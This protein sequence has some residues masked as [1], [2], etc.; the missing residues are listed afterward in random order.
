[1]SSDDPSLGDLIEQAIARCRGSISTMIPAV[2]TSFD[3][4]T[5][6]C[7]AKPAIMGREADPDTDVLLPLELQEVSNV[8]VQYQ[9]GGGCSFTFPLVPGDFVMLIMAEQSLDEWKTT[10]S[11]LSLPVDIRRF[12]PTDAIAVPGIRPPGMPLPPSAYAPGAVVLSAP[13]ILLG[14]SAA[15]SPLVL[16]TLLVAYLGQLLTWLNLH[17]HTGPGGLTGPP[18]PITGPAP[19]PGNLGAAKV[20]GE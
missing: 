12:D 9:Q 4:V 5:Q 3:P 17:V 11:P 18:A 1:M 13:S 15:S 2:V 6:T 20:M 7:S 16:M 10:G 14:S 19:Q 8:P